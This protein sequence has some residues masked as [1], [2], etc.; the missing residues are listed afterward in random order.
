MTDE[1]E[2]L[3]L[4][5]MNRWYC[6]TKCG[7]VGEKYSSRCFYTVHRCV[8]LCIKNPVTRYLGSP[9]LYSLNWLNCRHE[10]A[11]VT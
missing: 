7:E 9:D 3:V 2:E 6:Q 8:R 4:A 5:T 10:D 11:A 1:N